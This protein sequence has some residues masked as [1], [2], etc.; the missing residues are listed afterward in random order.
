[1]VSLTPWEHAEVDRTLREPSLRGG[2]RGFGTRKGRF[3]LHR[4][5]RFSHPTL[6]ERNSGGV[7]Q[8]VMGLANSL[9]SV[10]APFGII[11]FAEVSR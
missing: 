2:L 7:E 1:M 10:N 6:A 3:L 8:S 5:S 11:A 9:S 4:A